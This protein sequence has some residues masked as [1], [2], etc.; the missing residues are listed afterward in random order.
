MHWPPELSEGEVRQV[1]DLTCE[2]IRLPSVLGSEEAC[3]RRLLSAFRELGYDEVG[4]DE[5]GNVFGVIEGG[6]PGPVLLLD[7][8][9]DTVGVEPVERWQTPPW[10]GVVR[11][12]RILGRGA[13][14]MK[15][16]VAAMAVG[17]A[18]LE[19]ACLRGRVVVSGS[20]GEETT[21][22]TALRPILD[23][24][25]P[26]AVIIGETTSLAVAVGG[27]GRAEY[28]LQVEGRAAHA[29][30][31]ELGVSAVVLMAEVIQTI[32]RLVPREHALA[33]PGRWCVTD[34]IS[35]PFP[36]QS[37]VPFRCRATLERRLVPGESREAVEGEL[38]QVLRRAGVREYR[39]ELN[40]VVYRTWTGVELRAEKWY[41]AWLMDPED[42]FVKVAARAVEELGIRCRKTA[43]R[44][45]TNAAETAGVRGIPTIGFGPS[46]E[47]LAHVVDEWVA[48]E[49][50]ARAA[51]GYRA[52][53]ARFLGRP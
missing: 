51:A 20:V 27:R 50:L 42:G 34:I 53:A 29:S 7:G 32:Q 22:G 12:G 8:H 33:G 25:R 44:F 16:A 10:S 9:L 1:V 14:D 36:A 39:L 37:M 40:P 17:I 5:A 15:G 46:T 23:R 24:F 4:L 19:R 26:D 13:S 47:E 11:G 21:E 45:C 48:I 6:A 35:A 38:Q 43:Y 28:G 18:G 3:A 2:L 49:Q 52:M 41:P 30:S 31:P